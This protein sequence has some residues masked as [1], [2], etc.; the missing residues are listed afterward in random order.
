M[1]GLKVSAFVWTSN[2]ERARRFARK[3]RLIRTINHHRKIYSFE[4]IQKTAIR[5]RYPARHDSRQELYAFIHHQFNLTSWISLPC[6]TQACNGSWDKSDVSTNNEEI[7]EQDQRSRRFCRT[8]DG[9]ARANSQNWNESFPAN[10]HNALYPSLE[11][12]KAFM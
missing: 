7:A 2:I 3:I 9:G 5:P 1:R 10:P 12:G 11:G 4:I 6:Q 8:T